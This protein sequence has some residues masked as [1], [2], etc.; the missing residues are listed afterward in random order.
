MKRFILLLALIGLPGC[1]DGSRKLTLAFISNNP[2][3]F[4]TIARRGTEAAAKTFDINVEFYMPAYGTASEQHRIV[5]DLV[6][7]GVKG[8]AI[9][10]NDAGHQSRVLD[11][12]IPKNVGFIT[13]DSDLPPGSKRLCYIG[14]DN[15]KAG[16]AV[17]KLVMEALGEKGGKIMIYVGMLDVQN[18]QERRQGVIAALGGFKAE[19]AKSAAAKKLAAPDHI[20]NLSGK[21]EILGTMTD[22]GSFPKCKSNVEDTLNKYG[23]INCMVGLWAYNPPAML[24]GVK[25]AGKLGTIKLVGFDEDEET[26]Q[27]I[28]DGAIYA[29]VV[30]NPYMFGFM[31][32]DILQHQARKGRLP[33]YIPA[34]RNY[35]VPHRVIRRKDQ[36]QKG[37]LF[38][39][40]VEEFHKD[41]KKKKRGP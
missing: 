30:Q 27:A 23:D 40:D 39:E 35:Y 16:W 24:Q 20:T 2:H 13:Q 4:W 6:V 21:Y 7:K 18:A 41:L 19:E 29:T 37:Q 31:A 11:G 36:V 17:G 5:E 8:I 25:A 22:Q 14:T 32:M 33:D 3:E 26:L 9:S 38:D 15:V 10:P 1:M 34:D 28:K 12:I